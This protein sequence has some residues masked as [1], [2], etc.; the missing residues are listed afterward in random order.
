MQWVATPNIPEKYVFLLKKYIFLIFYPLFWNSNAKAYRISLWDRKIFLENR[1]NLGLIQSVFVHNHQLKKIVPAH[2]VIIDIGAHTGEFAL[3][4]DIYL[5]AKTVYSFE[6]VAKSYALLAQNKKD[7]TYH[8][9]ISTKPNLVMHI[10]KHTAMTSPFP[11]PG[12]STQERTACTT[13]DAMPEI[14]S[15][16]SIDLLKIDVEGMEYDVLAASTQTLQK[17]Q[18]ILLEMSVNRPSS[19]PALETL[20]Y[21]ATI[22]PGIALTHIGQIFQDNTKVIAADMVFHRPK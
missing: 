5:R 6:P 20:S 16:S 18:H 2:G 19:K 9:A 15:I 10:P 1:E 14:R 3:F 8:M 13:L 22:I 12:E 11:V 7:H 21:L 4:C 17:S